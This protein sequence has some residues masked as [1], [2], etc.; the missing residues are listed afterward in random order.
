MQVN[1]KQ[2]VEIITFQKHI[3]LQVH[4]KNLFYSNVFL[5]YFLVYITVSTKSG[6]RI[7]WR[8]CDHIFSANLF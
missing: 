3:I 2:S 6:T 8:L 5:P 4:T 7:S 1:A